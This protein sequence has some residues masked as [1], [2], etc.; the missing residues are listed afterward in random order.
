MRKVILYIAASLDNFIAREDGAV[1]WLED[2]P[3]PQ[4]SDFGYGDF[5]SSINTTSMGNNTYKQVLEFGVP[6]PYIG[7]TNYVFT[8]SQIVQKHDFVTF[9]N[10][11][12]VDFVDKLKE[13]E[14]KNIWL[15]GGGVINSLL[16]NAGLIDKM[17][18]TMFPTILGQGIPMFSND[19]KEVQ[20]NLS[21]CETL[22]NGLIQLTFNKKGMH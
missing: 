10:D 20:F 4:K 3:N 15:I 11:D 18:I 9:I 2:I 13:K 12:P 17:I 19:V 8:K 1:D 5:Y 22:Y 14:G 21:R 16:L 6:F 7:K